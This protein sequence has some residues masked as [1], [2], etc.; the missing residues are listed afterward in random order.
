MFAVVCL[1]ALSALVLRAQDE[2]IRVTVLGKAAPEASDLATAGPP[3]TVRGMVVNAATGE[4]LERALV[5]IGNS[6]EKG[7]LTDSGGR[8]TIPGVPSGLQSATVTKP[9]FGDAGGSWD[10]TEYALRLVR[11]TKDMPELKL[12]IRPQNSIHGQVTLST[13]LPGEGIGL[14]LLRKVVAD[15]R[16]A[17][18][19]SGE[20]RR[21]SPS[22][23]FRF[24]GLVDGTYLLKTLPD[25]ENLRAQRP[26]CNAEAPAE[27]PGYATTFFG[28]SQDAMGA[29]RIV[30]KGGDNVEAN[31]S[32]NLIQ[33]HLAQIAMQGAPATGN[34]SYEH[35]LVDGY[36][37]S[38]ST[39]IQEEKD[40]TLCTYLPDGAYTLMVYATPDEDSPEGVVGLQ[41]PAAQV[42][43]DR[44]GVLNFGIEG[45]ADR[46]LRLGL[47]AAAQTPVYLHFEP[48]PPSAE[49]RAALKE[50]MGERMPLD[51]SAVP[52]TGLSHGE[53][54]LASVFPIDEQRYAIAATAPGGYWLQAST[55]MPGACLG[56]VTSAG[57][58]LAAQPWVAGPSGA[59]A[60]VDVVLRTD[61]A[62]LTL[63]MAANLAVESAGEGTIYYIYAVPEFSSLAGVSTARLEQFADRTVTLEGLTPGRYRVYTF[64]TPRKLE[65]RNPEAM[66]QLGV[67]REIT[68]EPRTDSRLVIEEAAQ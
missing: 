20:E 28:G 26:E 45:N 64:R 46:G 57:Q 9:G 18:V 68:L 19:R 34:W 15:G 53:A 22:G 23:S 17:W 58:D 63:Q 62:K 51:L 16:A 8:F 36:G 5:K 60:A 11:V 59:G 44:S 43:R 27:M 7:A 35:V 42:S 61:C 56:D 2:P 50:G 52:V 30:V 29:A 48:G 47:S 12:E 31:L 4:G 65:F 54:A 39:P 49:T 37:Q 13:G 3:V 21:S 66:N 25:F 24:S 14:V 55:G 33:F 1:L 41:R 67:G 10:D 40:H 32:L 38:S 6:R